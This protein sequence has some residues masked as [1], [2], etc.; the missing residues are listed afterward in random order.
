MHES[1][2]TGTQNSVNILT[3]IHT[4]HLINPCKQILCIMKYGVNRVTLV[5]V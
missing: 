1:L 5:G 4:P 3:D 2:L